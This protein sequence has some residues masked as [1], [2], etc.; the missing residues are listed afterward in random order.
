[1]IIFEIAEAEGCLQQ[2]FYQRTA[3]PAERAVKFS[4]QLPPAECRRIQGVP[5]QP[6]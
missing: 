2:N 6:R 4:N 5:Y 1:M 3:S